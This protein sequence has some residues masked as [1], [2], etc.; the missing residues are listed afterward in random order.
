MLEHM[1]A[2][3][4]KWHQGDDKGGDWSN[5]SDDHYEGELLPLEGT[6]SVVW[7]FFGFPIEN[8]K[9]IAGKHDRTDVF[10]SM[11]LMWYK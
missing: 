7:K 9:I 3:S 5:P 10:C 6:T 4:I 1:H 11:K 2:P 8:G